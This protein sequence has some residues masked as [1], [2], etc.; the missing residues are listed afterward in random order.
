MSK[1][2][3]LRINPDDGL[4]YRTNLCDMQAYYRVAYK[5]F[6]ARVARKIGSSLMI[7]VFLGGW[8]KDL[9]KYDTIIMFDNGYHR[10][11]AKYIKRHNP[12]CRV[13]LWFW[14]RVFEENEGYLRDKIVDEIWSYSPYDC[15]KYGL[16]YNTQFYMKNNVVKSGEIKWDLIFLGAEKGR[17][18]TLDLVKEK[19]GEL[20]IKTKMIMP[21]VESERVKYAD[22]LK[23]VG[24]SRAILDMVDVAES[25]LTLRCIE[26]LA[27]GKKLVTNNA[28]IK[29]YDFYRPENVLVFDEEDGL[30]KLKAFMDE[31]NFAI[32]RETI[33]YY[34]FENWLNRFNER[35]KK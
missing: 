11:I 23:M 2:M 22:Y 3:I 13:I 30:E 7:G 8:K 21:K 12:K 1:I 20:G 19:C 14:N 32:K 29:Q 10:T 4:M 27:N 28:S 18:K 24:E 26:A 25:G 34:E 17:K 9:S 33:E 6:F 35:R 5:N 31:P 15:E 16:K